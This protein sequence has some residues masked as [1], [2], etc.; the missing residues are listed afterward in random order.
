MDGRKIIKEI[1]ALRMDSKYEKQCTTITNMIL[2]NDISMLLSIR[3]DSGKTTNSLLVGLILY[4][5]YN[6]TIEY[7]RSD[8]EQTTKAN[9]ETLFKYVSYNEVIGRNY[10]ADI[11]NNEFNDVTYRA[12]QKKFY[13]VYRDID[14]NIIK[15]DTNPCLVVHS[16]EEYKRIKSTYNNPKGNFILYDEF[17]DTN[18]ATYNQMIEWCNNISTIGRN[19]EECHCLMLGNNTNQFSFWFEEYCLSEDIKTLDFGGY[20]RKKSELGTTIEVR[21]LEVSQERKEQNNNKLIRFFGF[22]TPKMSAFNGLSAWQ[23]SNWQHIPNREFLT[24]GEMLDNRFWIKHRG[25][26][27]RI[28]IYSVND[29]EIVYLHFSKEP[30]LNDGI[31]FTLEPVESVDIYGMG[32]YEEGIFKE[33]SNILLKC[34]KTNSFYYSTNQVGDLFSDY[35]TT[36]RKGGH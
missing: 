21:L 25:R 30:L 36:M 2:F 34:Y 7:I 12:N 20:I 23:G 35:I 18:R 5:L 32:Q 4:K 31:V 16:N 6:Y 26:Y 10:I 33:I 29:R 14:N 22:N 8:K 3:Q 28:N 1:K 19:R 13:L 27:M 17:M 24:D 9:M 11:F 15:E